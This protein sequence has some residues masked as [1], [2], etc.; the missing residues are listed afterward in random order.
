MHHRLHRPAIWHLWFW[1][2]NSWNKNRLKNPLPHTVFGM[3][4]VT[5]QGSAVKSCHSAPPFFP[6]L[7][8]N[9]PH[10]IWK[11]FS[12]VRTRLL[13]EFL[14]T[15]RLIYV[16]NVLETGKGIFENHCTYGHA[17]ASYRR[18]S[19]ILTLKA[20]G[21]GR[22]QG[23]ETQWEEKNTISSTRVNKDLFSFP[24]CNERDFIYVIL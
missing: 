4:A 21:V 17:E 1:N 8:A 7:T 24:S 15:L 22:D 10:I 18:V 14:F 9:I 5:L 6:W 13:H 2:I 12:Q 19:Q 3:T 23:R 16:K 20:W 11:C